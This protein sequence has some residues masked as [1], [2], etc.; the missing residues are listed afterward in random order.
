MTVYM[1]VGL[2]GAPIFANFKAGFG[3]LLDPTGGF[4]IAFIIVAYVSGKLVEQK[5]RPTFITFTIASFTGIILTYII[6]T[7]YMYGA[8]NLFMGGNMSYKAAWMIMMW[9][10]VKRYCIYNYRCYY[11][12]SH[13]LCCA[14]LC[15]SAFSFDDFIIKKMSYFSILK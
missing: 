6:G 7:T 4:I 9:F 1:L 14:S 8:V 15:L 10:A 2:A 12:T 11:R 3:A 13:I 5:E